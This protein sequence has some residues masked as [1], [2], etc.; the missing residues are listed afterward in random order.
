[1]LGDSF[2]QK[3]LGSS[4]GARCTKKVLVYSTR[5]KDGAYAFNGS[6]SACIITPVLLVDLQSLKYLPS[7]SQRKCLLSLLLKDRQVS[8]MEIQVSIAAVYR[9]CSVFYC[10]RH[11]GDIMSQF[12]E[13]VLHT[14]VFYGISA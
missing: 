8:G 5:A 7:S 6:V 12:F 1:M 9:V 14:S 13:Q 11:T 2:K 10:S 4:P 3:S